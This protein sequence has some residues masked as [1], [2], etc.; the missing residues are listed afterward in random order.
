MIQDVG[1]YKDIKGLYNTVCS[2]AINKIQKVMS[3]F[4]IKN[5]PISFL[6]GGVQFSTR[7]EVH[8]ISPLPPS[9]LKGTLL[10]VQNELHKL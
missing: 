10:F 7:R 5:Y 3:Y 1:I 9:L 4:H 2:K 6:P 8:F